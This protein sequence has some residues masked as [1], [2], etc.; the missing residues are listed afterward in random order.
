MRIEFLNNPLWTLCHS[1]NEEGDRGRKKEMKSER[2]FGSGS[3]ISYIDGIQ[4]K[5]KLV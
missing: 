2:E 3:R 5:S 1:E 4:R